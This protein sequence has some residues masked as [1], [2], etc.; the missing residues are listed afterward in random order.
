MKVSYCLAALL[1]LYLISLV[2]LFPLISFFFLYLDGWVTYFVCSDHRFLKYIYCDF[3]YHHYIGANNQNS[4]SCCGSSSGSSDFSSRISDF[5][6][7]VSTVSTSLRRIS[8]GIEDLA[9]CIYNSGISKADS[10]GCC[11]STVE[12]RSNNSEYRDHPHH[13][14]YNDNTI[15]INSK[16]QN[17]NKVS[18]KSKCI[19]KRSSLFSTEG[20]LFKIEPSFRII[21]QYDPNIDRHTSNKYNECRPIVT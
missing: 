21:K 8:S 19:S 11:N 1:Y 10:I 18:N 20:H 12:N 15:E 14:D 2:S 17:G 4:T 13:S 16:N 7:C 5:G 9:G 6:S 3:H